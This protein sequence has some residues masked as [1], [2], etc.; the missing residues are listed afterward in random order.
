METEILSTTLDKKQKCSHIFNYMRKK[1]YFAYTNNFPFVHGFVCPPQQSIWLSMHVNPLL[2]VFLMV[3]SSSLCGE[4]ITDKRGSEKTF[5][6][7]L[8]IKELS[9]H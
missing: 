4:K 7:R 9:A 8:L 2:Q 1:F 3:S 5:Q 6:Q